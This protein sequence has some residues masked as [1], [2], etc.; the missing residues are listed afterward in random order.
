MT[1]LRD[2]RFQKALQAAPDADARVP[3]AIAE[4][5]RAAA[6]S[7][8][9]QPGPAKEA[10]TPWW[11]RVW[12]GS[13]Q[14]RGPWGAALATVV[15]GVLVT[16]LWIDEPLP[17]GQPLPPDFAPAPVVS[18][19]P[20]VGPVGS[21]EALPGKP[22]QEAATVS[23][24]ATAPPSAAPRVQSG[25]TSAKAAA[26]SVPVAPAAPPPNAHLATEAAEA[27]ALA[28]VP[29]AEVPAVAAAPAAADRLKQPAPSVGA[30]PAPSTSPPAVAATAAATAA[31]TSI[32]VVPAPQALPPALAAAA[33]PMAK[34]AAPDS[35]PDTVD[36]AQQG[37]MLAADATTAQR[38]YALVQNLEA[39]AGAEGAGADAEGTPRAPLVLVFRTQG[40][41]VATFTLADRWA[42]WE[43]AGREPVRSLVSEAQ[44]AQVLQ[45]VREA[46]AAEP[47]R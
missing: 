3:Q 15:L 26:T 28:P 22:M 6:R 40:Q 13:G 21:S 16:T 4:S 27:R 30:A 17:G 2:A 8:A 43:R 29:S 7:A 1:E 5:I 10:H 42:T 24:K 44:A 47:A 25:A 31:A 46:Q 41:R 19:A 32:A 36:I 37:R 38:L 45:A 12:A 34:R 39:P 14:T 18:D 11:R 33:A 23:G 9:A 20:A 35:K